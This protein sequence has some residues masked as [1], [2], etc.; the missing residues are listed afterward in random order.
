MGPA[1]DLGPARVRAFFAHI[2]ACSSWAL[3]VAVGRLASTLAQLGP[4]V[5]SDRLQATAYPLPAG[6]LS[7]LPTGRAWHHLAPHHTALSLTLGPSYVV[8]SLARGYWNAAPALSG[9]PTPMSTLP[10]PVPSPAGAI[11]YLDTLAVPSASPA[12]APTL[13]LSLL[14]HRTQRPTRPAWCQLLALGVESFLL[15]LEGWALDTFIAPSAL[16]LHNEFVTT[17]LTLSGSF[18]A[19]PAFGSLG[20]F[21]AVYVYLRTAS[22]LFATLVGLVV[23]PYLTTLGSYAHTSTPLLALVLGV[24]SYLF[25]WCIYLHSYLAHPQ[26][27]WHHIIVTNAVFVRTYGT[28]LHSLIA[29]TPP[30][31]SSVQRMLF[32]STPL[33]R[34][35]GSPYT[36]GCLILPRFSAH[37]TRLTPL[38]IPSPSRVI[39]GAH[40]LIS[41]LLSFVGVRLHPAVVVYLCA[42]LAS[43]ASNPLSIDL[44]L[45]RPSQ[46]WVHI[47]AWL[48][49]TLHGP[50]VFLF[51]V[52]SSCRAP[53]P[54]IFFLDPVTFF[55]ACSPDPSLSFF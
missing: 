21:D 11:S 41:A 38:L 8:S 49:A 33:P 19:V 36:W 48:T 50:R 43:I 44:S 2:G 20:L 12:P 45:L 51:G 42:P 10:T 5:L 55:L 15:R 24:R 52:L 32:H 46:S 22:L 35:A 4:L 53:D 31:T 13:P 29:G 26:A 39:F 47:S 17:L 9:V 6:G 37:G 1:L 27:L 28:A 3:S 34:P 16:P 14:R 30:L 18:L 54:L 40:D 7:F 23:G 25:F